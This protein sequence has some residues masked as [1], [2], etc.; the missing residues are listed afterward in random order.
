MLQAK[1]GNRRGLVEHRETDRRSVDLSWQRLLK[2]RTQR[3]A[4]VLA[5]VDGVMG[6]ILCGSMGRGDPW[7]LSDIDMILI[8]EDGQSEAAAHEVEA[9][10]Q[11]LSDWWAEEGYSTGSD[12]GKLASTRSEVEQALSLPPGGAAHVLDNERWFHSTEKGYGGRAVFDPEGVA[13][14]LSQWLTEARF[15]SEVVRRRL[16]I[17]QS[18]AWQRYEEAKAA[19]DEQNTLQAAIA[20]RESL[21]AL[22]RYL[23]ELWGDETTLG[24]GSALGSSLPLLREG[25]Q[26]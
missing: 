1:D 10:R 7:P 23:M 4:E 26:I 18:Q 24:G 12:V 15:A 19:L 9:R 14:A 21:H 2:Q 20:L 3:A 6:L 13:R 11:E 8:Y 16:E 25:K 22:T 17:H 5:G